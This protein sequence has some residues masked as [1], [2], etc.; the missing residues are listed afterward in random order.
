[1]EAYNYALPDGTNL[2]PNHG[3][4]GMESTVLNDQVLAHPPSDDPALDLSDRDTN[5]KKWSLGD[6]LTPEPDGTNFCTVKDPYDTEQ[7]LKYR[8]AVPPDSTGDGGVAAIRA[9]SAKY[10]WKNPRFY[11]TPSLPGTQLVADLDLTITEGLEDGGAGTPCTGS[12]H[13]VGLWPQVDCA[14]DDPADTDGLD[15]TKCSPEADNS[16]GRPTGSGISPDL[17]TV[18]HP[19]LHW[20]VL[21][22]EPQTL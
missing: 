21:P 7:V 2:D 16:K 5:H 13:V 1:V 19:V 22:G 3:S 17:K 18:C 20:C 8:A 4:L 9:Y 15:E 10:H 12:V 11:N 6:W 14:A